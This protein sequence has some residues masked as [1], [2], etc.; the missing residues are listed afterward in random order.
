VKNP[1]PL[2]TAGILVV[3]LGLAFAWELARHRDF[4]LITLLFAVV[5]SLVA[6]FGLI[7]RTPA[8]VE[9]FRAKRQGEDQALAG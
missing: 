2:K 7:R 1:K 8:T 4:S 3:I 5:L 9:H 6:L